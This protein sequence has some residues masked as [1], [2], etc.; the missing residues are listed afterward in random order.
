METIE[1][2]I[3]DTILSEIGLEGISLQNFI[4]EAIQDK[5]NSQKTPSHNSIENQLKEGYLS[6]YKEDKSLADDF[7]HIDLENID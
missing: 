6:S 7:E 2:K 5:V 4:L 3:S 1:I